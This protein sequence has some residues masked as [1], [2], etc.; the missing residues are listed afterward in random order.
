MSVEEV[1]IG[2]G[3]HTSEA[4]QWAYSAGWLAIGVGLLAAGVMR[5][6][7][8]MRLASALIVVLTVLKVFLIDLSVLQGLWRAVSFLALG[9][10]LLALALVYQ[11]LVFRDGARAASAPPPADSAGA[12]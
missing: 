9:G 12:S 7:R 3:R 2:V 6:S 5:Q 10:V 4:E 1:G 11:R 8:E